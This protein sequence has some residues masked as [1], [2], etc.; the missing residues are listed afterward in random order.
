VPLQS[1]E[2]VKVDGDR[3]QVVFDPVHETDK[4]R[5]T[6]TAK[7]DVGEDSATGR[8]VVRGRCQSP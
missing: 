1:T 5:Y 8:L 6:C 3:G 2:S 4:G 7:N